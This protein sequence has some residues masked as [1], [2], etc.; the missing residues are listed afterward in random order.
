MIEEIDS[1]L[2]QTRFGAYFAVINRDQKLTSLKSVTA[3]ENGELQQLIDDMTEVSDRAVVLVRF[4]ERFPEERMR[5][6]VRQWAQ[7]LGERESRILDVLLVSPTHWW[8]AM[9][10]DQ[11]CCPQTGRPRLSPRFTPLSGSQRKLLWTDWQ[12]LLSDNRLISEWA[13]ERLATLIDGLVDLRLRDCILAHAGH[14]VDQRTAWTNVVLVLL[15]NPNFSRNVALKTTLCALTYL[16]GDLNAARAIA[17]E[18]LNIDGNY[19]LALLLHKGLVTKAPP[20]TLEAAFRN[21]S[22][23]ALID[24]EKMSA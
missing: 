9:C 14:H 19:S 4:P 2:E 11:D 13:P 21:A 10:H 3:V 6:G 7:S 23:E 22:I 24:G 1:L 5:S 17:E 15:D 18:A 16:R 8:S 12:E 20:G